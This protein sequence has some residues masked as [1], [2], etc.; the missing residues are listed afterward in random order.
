MQWLITA[1]FKH[2]YSPLISSHTLPILLSPIVALIMWHLLSPSPPPLLLLHPREKTAGINNDE[3][4]FKVR[5]LKPLS[6]QNGQISLSVACY[7]KEALS[8]ACFCFTLR[9][10]TYI[11]NTAIMHLHPKSLHHLSYAYKLITRILF[12]LSDS[13]YLKLEGDEAALAQAYCTHLRLYFAYKCTLQCHHL[14]KE[15]EEILWTAVSVLFDSVIL[16]F[17]FCHFQKSGPVRCVCSQTWRLM[18]M[19]IYDRRFISSQIAPFWLT[20]HSKWTSVCSAASQLW[21][22][23]TLAYTH[24]QPVLSLCTC[25]TGHPPYAPLHL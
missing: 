8:R 10:Y 3:N 22:A 12:M 25:H 7:E 1:H 4:F 5:S 19:Q 9:S 23:L 13:Q 20:S 16:S 18:L 17:F 2:G 24:L 11:P 14:L 21:S 6:H 15:Q